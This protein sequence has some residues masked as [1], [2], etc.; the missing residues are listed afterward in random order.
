MSEFWIWF[1]TGVEHILDLNGYDHILFVTLLVFSYSF[2]KWAKLLLLISAF[3]IGHSISLALAVT[4]Q[5][6]LPVTLV[7]FSIGFSILITAVYH[8]LNFKK[9]EDKNSVFLIFVV[10]FFGL[11]HGLGFSYL[12]K[13][14]LG[15]EE[16]V[17]YPLLYFNLGLEVGQLIIVS[18]VL[19]F[20]IIMA[21]VF[22]CPFKLYK[23]TLVSVIGIIAL[24]ITSKRFLDF[25]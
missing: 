6:T 5:I 8:L 10:S 4:N 2:N 20:S 9:T 23:Y 1:S 22:K 21:F 18:I 16:S 19:L 13:S 17:F 25:F 3:T 24:I 7:E 11:I 12:L 14:M 15:R